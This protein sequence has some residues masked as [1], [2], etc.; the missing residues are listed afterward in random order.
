MKRVLN[1]YFI[2]AC[3][4]LQ[5][6]ENNF[7]INEPEFNLVNYQIE[8]S[9]GK[10]EVY[11]NGEL[12]GIV[13]IP[14]YKVTFN[15]DESADVISIYPG[16]IGGEFSYK[17]GRIAK[18]TSFDFSFDTN[19]FFGTQD[20]TTQFFVMASPDYNGAGD[21]ESIHN[22]TWIDITNMFEIPERLPTNSEYYPSGSVNLHEMLEEKGALSLA[23]KYMV[24]DQLTF[25]E[26]AAIR[27]RNW[28]LLSKFEF[29]EEEQNLDLKWTLTESEGIKNGRNS[30]SSSTIT[31]R[32]NAGYNNGKP[33]EANRPWVEMQTEA[34]VISDKFSAGNVNLGA[35]KA[36]PIKIFGDP[37]L[38]SYTYTYTKAGEYDVVFM[39]SNVNVESEKKIYK[40][41]HISIPESVSTVK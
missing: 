25:G 21:L 30:I 17:S 9:T 31:L 1:I 20:P 33:T 26:Y 7:E 40:T 19:V 28:K 27:I 3:M 29:V 8:E 23:F 13:D 5:S 38:K 14:V 35:D 24:N 12:V 10:K 22:A 36:T 41:V 34:W 2:I 18:R 4:F 39:L 15:F 32:G 11:E 16:D 37:T 6:C